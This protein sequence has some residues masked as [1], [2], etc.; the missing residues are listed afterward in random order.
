MLIGR[1]LPMS[2]LDD[3]LNEVNVS[4][5]NMTNKM[6]LTWVK[7]SKHPAFFWLSC[8]SCSAPGSLCS[9]APA[10][11]V[12]DRS[13]D[14]NRQ[15]VAQWSPPLSEVTTVSLPLLGGKLCAPSGGAIPWQG[16][17]VGNGP[18]LGW[19]RPH[20]GS[21]FPSVPLWFFLPSRR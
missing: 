5:I 8:L 10:A 17:A 21:A 11:P 14:L 13:H 3:T 4:T 16:A 15:W 7:C 20:W 18:L 2:I 1:E 19:P 9:V 12:G 6:T